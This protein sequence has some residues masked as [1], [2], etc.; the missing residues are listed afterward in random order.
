MLFI[1]GASCVKCN[2]AQ[3]NFYRFGS[4]VS[5]VAR[6]GVADCMNVHVRHVCDEHGVPGH[7]Y[8]HFWLY[9]AGPDKVYVCTVRH[10]LRSYDG[11]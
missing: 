2:E 11:H 3:S 1:N 8:P 6:V 9:S 4:D 7:N 5:G 10:L